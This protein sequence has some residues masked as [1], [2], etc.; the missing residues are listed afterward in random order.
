MSEVDYRSTEELEKQSLGFKLPVLG[1][2]LFP[3]L[4]SSLG[5]NPVNKK[6]PK[7]MFMPKLID[8]QIEDISFRSDQFIVGFRFT[9]VLHGCLDHYCSFGPYLE[10]LFIPVHQCYRVF[11]SHKR[12]K[13]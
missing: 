8:P 7:L 4:F 6:V 11:F 13:C 12:K 3:F 5:K 2:I 1:G 10:W 9:H